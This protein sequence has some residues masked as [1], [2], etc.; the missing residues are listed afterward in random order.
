MPAQYAN[1]YLTLQLGRKQVPISLNLFS[2]ITFVT[3]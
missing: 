2:F 1:R 3:I